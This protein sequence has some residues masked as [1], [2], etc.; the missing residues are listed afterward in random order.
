[1]HY[2]LFAIS[3]C[4]IIRLIVRPVQEEMLG[5]L[6]ADAF[7]LPLIPQPY[8]PAHT[9]YQ[10]TGLLTKNKRDDIQGGERNNTGMEL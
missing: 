8:A 2:K 1:M 9:V 10:L 3:L 6:V 5:Y 7:G 4:L